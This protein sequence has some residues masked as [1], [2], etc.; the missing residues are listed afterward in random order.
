MNFSPAPDVSGGT[1]A[2]VPTE[3]GPK[4]HIAQ[5]PSDTLTIWFVNTL[6]IQDVRYDITYYGPFLRDLPRRF[7][8]SPVLDAAATALVS[9]YPYFQKQDVPPA[10]LVKFGKALKALRECLKDP[11]SARSPNTLCAIYLI[12]IC[13]SW[14]GTPQ[15]QRSGHAEAIT[16]ILRIVDLN[17]YRSEFARNLLVTLCVPV[18]LEGMRNPRIRMDKQIWDQITSFFCQNPSSSEHSSIPRP[19]TSLFSI[20]MFPEYI[21]NPSPYLPEIT[22]AYSQLKIDVQ[23]MHAFQNGGFLSSL[24]TVH[25]SRYLAAYTVISSLTLMLNN[26]L[27]AFNPL[28]TLLANDSGSFVQQIIEGADFASRDRPLGT[29]YVPLCLIVALAAAKDPEQVTRIETTLTDYQSDFKALE[30]RKCVRW[31]KTLLE[32][33][34]LHRGLTEAGFDVDTSELGVPGGCA[35]M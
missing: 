1:S 21:H 24:P 12:S 11:I 6:E 8:S 32:N 31:L 14:I 30:W 22:Q 13:Q 16:H 10:V 33:L 18:I 23:N 26:I 5:V 34:H 7:G 20:A 3:Q 35:M 27:H 29:A 9:S 19:T 4:L 15:K 25:Q 2:V 17:E 28:D